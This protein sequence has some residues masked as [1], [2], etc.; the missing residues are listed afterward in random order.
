MY[1]I[2]MFLLWETTPVFCLFPLTHQM[3][4]ADDCSSLSLVVLQ[5][6]ILTF[7][8]CLVLQ[9]FHLKI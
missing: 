1:S 9:S 8:F 7:C 3:V 4:T 5:G 2:F 6:I